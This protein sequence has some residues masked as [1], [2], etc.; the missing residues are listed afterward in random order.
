MLAATVDAT[1]A[2]VMKPHNENDEDEPAEP[3]RGFG[4]MSVSSKS[5]KV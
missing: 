5:E 4:Q 3:G 2:I 1:T